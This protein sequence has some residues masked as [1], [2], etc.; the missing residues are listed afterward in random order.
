MNG[1]NEVLLVGTLTKTPELRATN[2]GKMVA[3]LR[4]AI[5]TNFGKKETLFVDVTAWEKDAENSEKYLDKGCNVLVQ[6]RL[7]ED[8]WTDKETGKKCS[9]L[10]V[11]ANNI[12]FLSM[13]PRDDNSK[14][15]KQEENNGKVL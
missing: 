15:P 4:L 5:N 12:Q 1:V 2:S 8:K 3:D 9:V 7:V 14:E 13:K 6:G 10:K 11:Y